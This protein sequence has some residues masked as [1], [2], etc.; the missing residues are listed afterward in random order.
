ML[1]PSLPALQAFDAVA[2]CGSVRRAAAELFVTPGAISRHVKLLEE[3]YGH[4]L[5]QRVGRG[6]A[7]T[8][9]GAELAEGLRPGF[10]HIRRADANTRSVGAKRVIKLRSYTTFATLWLLNRLA[11][12]QLANP[13]IEVHLS[14]SSS[15]SD[16]DDFDAAIRLGD[17]GWDGLEDVALV[18]NVL[19]PV[20]APGLAGR[21]GSVGDLRQFTLLSTPHRPDDWA[22]WLQAF[23]G[24]APGD[25]GFHSFESSAVAYQ[26]AIAGRGVAL[27]QLVL[28]EELLASGRLVQ[29]LPL[30]FDREGFTYRMVWAQTHRDQ[31]AIRRLCDALKA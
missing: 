17:G 21:I 20:C 23:G 5:L 22:L 8:R 13:E 12:F 2:R 1:L 7:L 6:V 9:R 16:L 19:S 3:F 10:E 27:A 29:P 18:P 14:M 28:A 15:W 31:R 30:E 26:A 4:P 11:A 25:L 24:P